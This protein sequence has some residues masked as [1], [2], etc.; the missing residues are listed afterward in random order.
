MGPTAQSWVDLAQQA[1]ATKGL[2]TG[3]LAG[4]IEIESGGNPNITHD[5]A[6]SIDRGIAQINNV[7]HPDVTNAQAYNPSFAIPWAANELSGLIGKCGS[8]VGGLEAYNSGR[9]SGDTG[10]ASAVLAA[11]KRY[12]YQGE[13]YL[14]PATSGG[15]GGQATGG[16]SGQAYTLVLILLSL[17]LLVI[18]AFGGRRRRGVADDGEAA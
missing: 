6:H 18:V 1:G 8:V 13:P 17:A 15:Q 3:L 14:V 4:L 7:A 9:C 5:N 2:P 12:G 10:Y 11:A 16:L